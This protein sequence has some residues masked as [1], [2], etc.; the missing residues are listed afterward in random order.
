[1]VQNKPKPRL[2]RPR[3]YDPGVALQRAVETFW[4]HG[5]SATSL[6][7]L[8]DAMDM[9]RPSLYAAFG[10]KHALYLRTMELY[11]QNS[12]TAIANALDPDIPLATV[13]RTF[14]E[15]AISWYLPKDDVARGCY[16]I[17]TATSEAAMDKDVRSALLASLRGIDDAIRKRFRHAAATGEIDSSADVEHLT[18]VAGAV[19]HKLAVRAR[20][21]ESKVVLKD[22]ID[23]T[24]SNLCTAPRKRAASGKRTRG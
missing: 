14:Y 9:N 1:M 4:K 2:G 3:A 5:Y 6:D 10:D 15:G 22:M 11:T 20:A 8:S 24:I 21:G 23:R 12:Q 7:Q 13:L 17:C 16:L 19:L 18:T